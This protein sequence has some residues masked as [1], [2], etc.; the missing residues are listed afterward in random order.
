MDL[1]SEFVGRLLEAPSYD[2]L[3]FVVELSIAAALLTRS[4]EHRVR[5]VARLAASAALTL[6]ISQLACALLGTGWLNLIRYAALL[7]LVMGELHLCFELTWQEA[8]YFGLAAYNVQHL[9]WRITYFMSSITGVS[10]FAAIPLNLIPLTAIE[11]A[12]SAAFLRSLRKNR[13]ATINNLQ[14]SAIVIVVIVSDLVL[15]YIPFVL[16][17]DFGAER[18]VA[19]LYAVLCCALLL[20]LQSGMLQQSKLQSEQEALRTLWELDRQ[21]SELTKRSVELINTRS[22]DLKKQISL[23]LADSANGDVDRRALDD[24]TAAIEDYDARAKTGNP[25]LDTLITQKNMQAK[26]QKTTLTCLIDGRE[27]AYLG[28]I[29]L[30]AL[31]GNILDNALEATAKVADPERRVID[32]N[33]T[34]QRNLL[35]VHCVNFFD[36]PAPKDSAGG[37]PASSKTD[38]E[39]HGFGLRSIRRVAESNGGN[40]E[41][42]AEDGVF[43]LKVVL[44]RP[45]SVPSPSSSP[46]K[47]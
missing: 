29:D 28:E 24:V 26:A 5:F 45:A 3:G 33:A 17:L 16:D 35:V 9:A 18:G 39:N 41:A 40:L 15:S 13:D 44:P 20:V 8:L 31:F 25:S 6:A 47:A 21:Q 7:A 36:G 43:H 12:V 42:Y 34:R 32:L 1:V 14:L 10:F 38:A 2:S 22:H 37:L 27:F 30:Y 19:D 11:A 4:E 46:A 23:I